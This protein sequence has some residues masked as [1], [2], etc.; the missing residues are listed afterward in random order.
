M[1]SEL[2]TCI[3]IVRSYVERND[4]DPPRVDLDWRVCL[5]W[6]VAHRLVTICAPAIERSEAPDDVRDECVRL[7]RDVK[8]RTALLYLELPR[9]CSRLEAGGCRPLV[10]KGGGLGQTVYQ[11]S[12]D[13]FMTDLDIL[14][15][16]GRLERALEALGDCGYRLVET[17]RH[18]RFYERHH[19]HRILRGPTGINVEVHWD[20][21]RPADYFRFDLEGLRERARSLTMD[22]ISIRLPEPADQLLHAAAQCID[23]GFTNVWRVVDGALLLRWGDLNTHGLARRAD[24]Q[25]V[26][27]ALWALLRLIDRLTG[28]ASPA[29]EQAL[30]PSRL[31]QRCIES[32]DLAGTMMNGFASR[33]S[34]HRRLVEWLCA[35]SGVRS[36]SQAARFVF[37]GEALLLAWGH[38]PDALPGPLKRTRIGLGQLWS[39]SKIVGYQGWCLATRR[40]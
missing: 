21:S 13:R 39:L 25:G 28:V 2:D 40:R 17:S 7:A 4:V 35:P 12:G 14:V 29:L 23:E 22:G 19:F 36:L 3:A 1:N 27:S 10:L 15:D 38:Q 31:R 34:G 16:R 8:R 11:G 6:I 20:V 30:A 5:Q 37:P 18:P 32:L 9:L 26:G 24:E 33:H